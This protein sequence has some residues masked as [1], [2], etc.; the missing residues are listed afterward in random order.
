M[1]ASTCFICGQ[2]LTA[3]GEHQICSLSCGHIFGFSCINDWF[4]LRPY[5]PIC[6]SSIKL[7][8]IQLLFWSASIQQDD[9]DLQK[10]QNETNMIKGENELLEQRIQEMKDK[11]TKEKE[12]LAKNVQITKS[13]TISEHYEI[14]YPG[15]I[16]ERTIDDG[17]RIHYSNHFFINSCKNGN[18]N[19]GIQYTSF[20]KLKNVS[21]L[22]LHSMQIRDIASNSTQITTCSLDK[23]MCISEIDE[24][25][26]LNRYTFEESLWSCLSINDN[27]IGVGGDR[28]LFSYLDPRMEN[29]IFTTNIPGPPVNSMVKLSDTAILGLTAKEFHFYDITKGGFF[30]P[31]EKLPGG[32]SLRG[33]NGSCFYVYLRRNNGIAT[34]T[35]CA[36]DQ[37]KQ[38]I[39]I[40]SSEIGMFKQIIRPSLISFNDVT[41]SAIPDEP[42]KDFSLYALNQPR[43]DL[44]SQW[45]TRFIS[46]NL[47]EN[48]IIDCTLFEEMNELMIATTTSNKIRIFS[49]P[50]I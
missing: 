7:K 39:N 33:C 50:P 28:G 41:Y 22:P 10:V 19:Y 23:S 6:Q 45:N 21:F 35:Y 34:V 1:S 17:F 38:L 25:K 3:T 37:N 4:S 44:W 2:P 11:L 27:L 20:K 26:I 40:L 16:Y 29:T 24:R 13:T 36:Y 49:V 46:S 8:D 43:F 42:N 5:C 15:L 31:Q 12:Y 18:N 14:T 30:Q 9:P 32:F 48:P 47:C